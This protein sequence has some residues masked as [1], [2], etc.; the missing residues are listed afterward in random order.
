MDT[1]LLNPLD[2]MTPE[3]STTLVMALPKGRILNELAPLLE[4]AGIHG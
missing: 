1:P 4:R 2:P 3:D